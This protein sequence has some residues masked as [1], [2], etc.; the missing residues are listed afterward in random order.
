M[1]G[2]PSSTTVT[3]YLTS[4]QQH[5]QVDPVE[6]SLAEEE[7]SKTAG[8]CTLGKGQVSQA[9]IPGQLSRWECRYF[10]ELSKILKLCI[11]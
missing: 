9:S 11:K 6:Q 3:D 7:H 2:P 4:S 5:N 8:V 1:F 10:G